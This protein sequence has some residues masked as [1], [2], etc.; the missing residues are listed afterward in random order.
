MLNSFAVALT[1]LVL[2]G[3]AS[4]PAV[5]DAARA[6][7]APTGKLRAGMNLGNALFTKKDPATGELRGVAVDVM[8]ELGRRLGVSRERARQLE[9]DH[10]GFFGI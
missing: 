10:A 6:Q 5:P 1:A 7:L 3:C 2:A 8:N 9:K 4:N